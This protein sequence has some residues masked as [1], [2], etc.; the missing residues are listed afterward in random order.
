MQ[1]SV[2][3]SEKTIGYDETKCIKLKIAGLLHDIGKLAIPKEILDKNGSLNKDEFSIIKSHP[4]YTNIILNRF[5]EIGD[6]GFWACNH[7][8]KLNGKGYPRGLKSKDLCEEDRVIAVCD[9][10][11]ALIEDRPYREG[12]DFNRAFSILDKMVSEGLLC[13]KA[14]YYLKKAITQKN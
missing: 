7:H 13:D 12:M 14:V 4:Y 3:R 2:I 1:N 5:G 8:E 10:Y 9:I 11:Q 6:I